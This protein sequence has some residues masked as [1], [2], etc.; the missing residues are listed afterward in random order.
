MPVKLL[1][2]FC[3]TFILLSCSD[4]AVNNNGS[5]SNAAL[6]QMTDSLSNYYRSQYQIGTGGFFLKIV[7]PSEDFFVSSNVNPSLSV[8]YHYRIAS[9][10]KTFTAASIMLLHQQGKLN[11]DDDITMN[12]PGTTTP[13]VPADSNW[14]LPFKNQITIKLLLQHRAGVFDLKNQPVPPGVSQPYAGQYYIEYIKSLPGNE[15]HTF[16]FDELAGVLS[17]NDLYNFAP[18]PNRY[19]YSNTGYSTLGKIIE[20]VSGLSYSEFL[21]LNFFVPLGLS[22]TISV[23]NG[24]DVEIPSPRIDSYLYDNGSMTGTTNDNMSANVA[25]G[26]L[27]STPADV[28]KWIHSLLTGNAGISAANVELMKQVLPTGPDGEAYGLGIAYIPGLGYGHN[29]A[30]LSYMDIAAYDPVKGNTMLVGTNFMYVAGLADQI[31]SMA[32][33][34]KSGLTVV[35]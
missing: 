11:I 32:D 30:H 25:E 29:G 17:V 1:S 31:R 26:N 6:Q 8:N 9:V 24:N 10:T 4:N 28:T 27:I 23:W 5:K 3:I 35:D 21:K 19:H 20:R 2:V 22:N 14:N 16:T 18:D 33:L 12:I 7:T 15:S 13:Y 34:V